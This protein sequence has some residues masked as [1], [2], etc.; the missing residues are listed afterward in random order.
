MFENLSLLAVDWNLGIN[1]T[2]TGIVIVFA[3]LVLLVLILS[4]FGSIFS[5]GSKVKAEK[6]AVEP[7]VVKKETPKV[8]A[9]V[10]ANTQNNDE[11]IA[12]IAA[13]VAAMY[14]GSDVQP[15]IRKIKRSNSKSRPAWTAA[16]IFENTR[17]F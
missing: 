14:E 2:I 12:V 6:P 10:V 13:A 3:M 8:S 9:P 11:I 15:V 5:K 16:G 1:V 4:A 17:A 7:T